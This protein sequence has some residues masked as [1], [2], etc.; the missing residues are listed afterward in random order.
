MAQVRFPRQ[1]NLFREPPQKIKKHKKNNFQ[2]F[3]VVVVSSR[4]EDRTKRVAASRQ[5]VASAVQA[6]T[7]ITIPKSAPVSEVLSSDKPV[8]RDDGPW[9]CPECGKSDSK[10]K[11][12]LKSHIRLKQKN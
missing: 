2:D 4:E 6:T 8:G 10:S 12:G 9:I 1:D 5:L 3:N 7:S 11:A